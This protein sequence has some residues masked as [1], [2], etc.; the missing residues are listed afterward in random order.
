MFAPLLPI[1]IILIGG[2]APLIGG[3][4]GLIPVVGEVLVGILFFLVLAVGAGLALIL[5]GG[6][7]G[8]AR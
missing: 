7:A 1:L 8:G 4:V 3:L 2:L 5:I 6:H